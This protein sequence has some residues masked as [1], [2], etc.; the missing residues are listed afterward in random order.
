MSSEVF[1]MRVE[2]LC[3]ALG[4]TLASAGAV[5]AQSATPAPSAKPAPI[6]HVKSLTVDAGE[7]RPGAV[8][9]GKFLFTNTGDR[10]VKILKAAPS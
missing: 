8:L 3:V 10:P 6:L 2:A 9:K 5:A 4:M 1:K 7:V